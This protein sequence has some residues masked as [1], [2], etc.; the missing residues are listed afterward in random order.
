MLRTTPDTT[1]LAKILEELDQVH[2]PCSVGAGSPL[3]LRE[4]GLIRDIRIGAG[5]EVEVQLRLTSPF[6]EMIGF[7]KRESIDKIARLEGVTSVEVTTDSGLA[8]TPE[9]MSD[10][11]RAKREERLKHLGIPSLA[12]PGTTPAGH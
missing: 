7:L 10:S 8:W 1:L 12:R 9:A 4:M 11:G 6:C 5:G 3:G 2:D